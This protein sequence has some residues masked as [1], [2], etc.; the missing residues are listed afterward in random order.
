MPSGDSLIRPRTLRPGDVIRV[1]APASPFRDEDLQ[2]GVSRLESWGYRVR[3]RDDIRSAWHYLAGSP[4]RRADEL[5]A[6]FADP[7]AAAIVPVR[8]GYGVTTLLPLLDPKLVR[9][10]PK[11]LVGCSDLTA[12]LQW[13][14]SEAGI[15]CFHGPMLGAIGRDDDPAGIER[16][17]QVLEHAG[18]PADLR[19]A[20]DDAHQWCFAPG[21]AKG[22]AMGGSLSLLA[23]LCGTPLQ[24]DTKGA[25]LFLED[26]GERPYR[27]DRLL[28]QLQHSGLFDAAE[29]VVLGDFV[30]C[31]E[32]KG[33]PTWRDAVDRV[34]RSLPI[35]VLAGVPFGHGNPNLLFPLGTRVRVDAGKG[36]VEFRESPL[37]SG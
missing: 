8:G 14:L 22:R 30:G 6:A 21:V 33:E 35:P 18:K 31:D 20:F 28:T 19:S 24:P 17:R 9:G 10:N 29:A 23:A 25:V 11:I 34:F 26:V 7:E 15:V 12:L 36:R 16:F 37:V 27:I 3:M 32:A 1:V 4:Q 13:M 2:A 5:H